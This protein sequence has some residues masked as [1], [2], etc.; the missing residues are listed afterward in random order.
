MSRTTTGL[1]PLNQIIAKSGY[2]Y[3]FRSGAII[4][5]LLYMDDIKL[6]ARSELDINSLIHITRIYNSIYNYFRMSFGQDK[7]G[8]RAGPVLGRHIWGNSQ[9]CE[10]GIM[11]TH[12]APAVFFSVLIVTVFLHWIGLLAMCP[13]PTWRSGLHFVR[14][15]PSDLSNFLFVSCWKLQQKISKLALFKKNAV[16]IWNSAEPQPGAG[17]YEGVSQTLA[18]A[19]WDWNSAQ[20]LDSERPFIWSRRMQVEP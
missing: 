16:I 1:N 17:L 19:G 6:Y 15:L 3:Q 5:N 18:G 4:S 9:K 10:G 20:E 12:H 2:E 13:T 8:R 14:P 11:C 7:C